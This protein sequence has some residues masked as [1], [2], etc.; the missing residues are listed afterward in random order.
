MLLSDVC[1][2]WRS[3]TAHYTRDGVLPNEGHTLFNWSIHALFPVE[4]FQ[5][6]LFI[7]AAASAICL[8]VGFYSRI[9]V[10]V[11]WV[12]VVSIH[13][14]NWMVLYG[15]D[16]LIRLLLFWSLWLPVGSRYSLDSWRLRLIN[17]P[18][19][20]PAHR[21]LSVASAALLIQIA[22]VYLSTGFLK[23]GAQWTRDFNALNYALSSDWFATDFGQWLSGFPGILKYLTV[24]VVS[25][26]RIAP[27]LLFV[28]FCLGIFRLAGI[29]L[30][31]AMLIG[32]SLTLRLG[33][34]P[35]IS[36]VALIPFVG[37]FVWDRKKA[38][39]DGARNLAGAGWIAN[40]LAVYFLAVVMFWNLG[41]VTQGIS[42]ISRVFTETARVLHLGQNWAMFAPEVEVTD[43]W[44]VV[45]GQEDEGKR[46]NLL[47]KE[48]ETVSFDRPRRASGLFSDHHW[49][50][51]FWNLRE[52]SKDALP[53]R[54]LANFLCTTHDELSSVSVVFFYYPNRATGLIAP[55]QSDR[56]I[57][58]PCRRKEATS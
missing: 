39:I 44:F 28:P 10:W 45:Y 19:I 8:T 29:A 6:L 48:A 21:Y 36:L 47:W 37:S 13:N 18:D 55:P 41:T 30:I 42:R 27:I 4:P 43:G 5:H 50:K 16:N 38:T 57:D 15:A 14:H 34:F 2:R 51:L 9:A 31:A 17:Q 49:N 54:Q 12:W 35:V 46:V 32:S 56:K 58:H 1:L 22:V 52:I 33:Y 11:G 3:L 24:F 53:Y 40:S 7:I 25:V 26:E 20:A 23:Q